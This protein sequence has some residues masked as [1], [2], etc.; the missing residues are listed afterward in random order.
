MNQE[1]ELKNSTKVRDW[2]HVSNCMRDNMTTQTHPAR[3]VTE[4]VC[5]RTAG[6]AA[7]E[8]DRKPHVGFRLGHAAH[9][10]TIHHGLRA[11]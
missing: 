3:V 10:L 11:G 5:V 9:G 4:C 8:R 1:I 2:K 6:A 7:C